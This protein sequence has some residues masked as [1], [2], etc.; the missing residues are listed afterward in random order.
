[1]HHVVQDTSI[2]AY[3]GEVVESLGAKH[4]EILKIFAANYTRNF[5]NAELAE[6]LRWPINTVT[7]RVY[8]LRG[9]DKN[10]PIKRDNPIIVEV[11]RRACEVTGR[12]AI[13]W[14]MNPEYK[15]SQYRGLMF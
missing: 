15:R 9:R 8:E 13:A 1:M 3:Y 2:N 6:E 10:V 7:P 4:Y 14:G 11:G 12:T 5:T